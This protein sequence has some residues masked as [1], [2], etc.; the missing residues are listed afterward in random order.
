MEKCWGC[1]PVETAPQAVCALVLCPG[2]F[3]PTCSK[4]V[5]NTSKDP[6][7]PLADNY[8][9]EKRH[10]PQRSILATLSFIT[11]AS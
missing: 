2:T 7:L 11:Q 6:S 5:K 4:A 3:S 9:C 10:S 8:D 1:N